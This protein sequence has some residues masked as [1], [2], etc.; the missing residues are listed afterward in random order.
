M[1]DILGQ[2]RYIENPQEYWLKENRRNVRNLKR[3]ICLAII[4]S[5]LISTFYLTVNA[6]T[7]VDKP[8]NIANNYI[9]NFSKDLSG[10]MSGVVSISIS[11]ITTLTTLSIIGLIQNQTSLLNDLP[12]DF[13]DLPISEIEPFFIILFIFIF[14]SIIRGLP[15]S[16]VF[17]IAT[18]DKIENWI[19]QIVA[20]LLI[21]LT[22]SVASVSVASNIASQGDES[23]VWVYLF[24]TA[25]TVILSIASGVIY[26]FIKTVCLGLDILTFL[27]ALFPGVSAFFQSIRNGLAGILMLL[28]VVNPIVSLIISIIIIGLS[29]YFFKRTYNIVIYFKYIYLQSF[30]KSIFQRNKLTPL[31]DKDAPHKITRMFPYV[32]MAIPI[33]PMNKIKDIR[34]REKCWF[35]YDGENFYICRNHLFKDPLCIPMGELLTE[36]DVVYLNRT[37]RFFRVFIDEQLVDSHKKILLVFSRVYNNQFYDILKMTGFEDYNELQAQKKEEKKREREAFIRERK[38]KRMEG[39]LARDEE[40]IALKIQNIEDKRIQLLAREK[41]KNIIKEKQLE[42]KSAL[43]GSKIQKKTNVAIGDIKE[44]TK[45]L[46]TKLNRFKRN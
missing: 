12:L 3:N 39:K 14:T 18:I 22:T 34:K 1:Q 38:E 11:P 10:A 21:S 4:I 5:L 8:E 2:R 35:V 30:W 36:N 19:G 20:V 46:L 37:M 15:F 13:S 16:K 9:V 7:S 43:N 6:N 31:V 41:N 32:E 25:L 33:F 24:S 28:T 17:T 23:S 29:I 45:G 27:T 40:R 44:T 42:Y 26:F